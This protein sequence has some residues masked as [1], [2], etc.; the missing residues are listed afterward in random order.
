MR[1]TQPA[2]F[3]GVHPTMAQ[4]KDSKPYTGKDLAEAELVYV[5][6]YASRCPHDPKHGNRTGCIQELAREMRRKGYL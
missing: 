3:A 5:R 4:V 6:S 1:M 2:L